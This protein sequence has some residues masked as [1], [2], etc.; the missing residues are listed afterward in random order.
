MRLTFLSADREVGDGTGDFGSSVG[1]HEKKEQCD[2]F[3]LA[4]G[5]HGDVPESV[6]F[7]GK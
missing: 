1:R 5:L 4:G 3:S 6:D 2:K 7:L